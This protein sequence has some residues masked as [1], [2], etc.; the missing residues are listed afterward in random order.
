MTFINKN[1]CNIGVPHRIS[2]MTIEAMRPTSRA[3]QKFTELCP[4]ESWASL[5]TRAD[6]LLVSTSASRPFISQQDDRKHRFDPIP[7]CFDEQDWQSLNEGLIQRGRCLNAVL[8]D[9]YGEQRSCYEGLLD[10]RKLFGLKNFILPAHGVTG[11]GLPQLHLFQVQVSRTS[12]G[13]RVVK[14]ITSVP[15]RLGMIL[16]HRMVGNRIFQ[17][18]QDE[19]CLK[20]LAHWFGQFRFL[21]FVVDGSFG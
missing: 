8:A 20:R 16:E 18:V 4:Q 10:I 19:M 13:F 9:L 21:T 12:A 6:E 17:N 15:Q 2:Y 1:M 7:Y 3:W 14:D 11:M 5:E